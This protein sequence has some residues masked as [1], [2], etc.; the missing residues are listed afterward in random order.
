MEL[1]LKTLRNKIDMWHSSQRRVRLHGYF[2]Q[3]KQLAEGI[4]SQDK[5]QSA[6]AGFRTCCMIGNVLVLPIRFYKD[7]LQFTH[8]SSR[9]AICSSFR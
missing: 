3:V 2:F 6:G 4:T 1:F 7:F 9:T 5:S 8:F